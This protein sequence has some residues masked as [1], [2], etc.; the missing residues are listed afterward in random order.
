MKVRELIAQLQTIDQELDVY[1]QKDDEGNGYSHVNGA[2]ADC[3]ID[4]SIVNQYDVEVLTKE[5][6]RYMIEEY[7]GREDQYRQVVVIY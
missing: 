5:D 4:V 7:G 6:V 1:K 3:H 2:D